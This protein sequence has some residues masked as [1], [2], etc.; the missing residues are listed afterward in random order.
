MEEAL[1]DTLEFVLVVWFFDAAQQGWLSWNPL[2]PPDLRELTQIISGRAYLVVVSETV[3][4]TFVGGEAGVSLPSMGTALVSG[5][6]N[7]AYGGLTGAVETVLAEA[8][9]VTVVVWFFDGQTQAWVSWNRALP[10]SLRALKQLVGGRAYFVVTE[11]ASSWTWFVPP[12]SAAAADAIVLDQVVV[13][14]EVTENLLLFR[15]PTVLAAGTP[16]QPGEIIPGREVSGLTPAVPSYLYFID[17]E[18]GARFE[19]DTRFV[20]VDATSGE[21]TVSNEDWWPQVDGAHLFTDDGAFW[22]PANHVFARLDPNPTPQQFLQATVPAPATSAAPTAALHSA[23]F[24]V[25]PRVP[26][27]ECAIVL[28]STAGAPA[29]EAATI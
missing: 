4:W 25:T 28:S 2:L 10:L 3:V 12:I 23:Q 9:G 20:L 8:A 17:D 14:D 29:T 27:G 24:P 7:V 6:N 21:V 15:H 13:P 19:H 18:P 11:G 5:M 16:V 26:A 22:N 1:N